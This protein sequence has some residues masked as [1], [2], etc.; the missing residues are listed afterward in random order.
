MKI[1]LFKDKGC[2]NC[3]LQEKILIDAEII[4]DSYDVSEYSQLA[5]LYNVSSLPTIIFVNELFPDEYET[6]KGLRPISTI[7]KYL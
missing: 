6:L 1:M 3:K 4:Y 7:R 2:N 5:S